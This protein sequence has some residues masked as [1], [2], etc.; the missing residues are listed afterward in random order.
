MRRSGDRAATRSWSSGSN[1]GL[2][3]EV[4]FLKHLFPPAQSGLSEGLGF[5]VYKGSSL[6]RGLWSPVR[7]VLK[8]V[9]FCRSE[10]PLILGS[11]TVK[12]CMNT[13]LNARNHKAL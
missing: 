6:D 9:G 3:S 13:F 2:R 11:L 8:D 4:L 1:F 5:R 10:V 12:A 7:E